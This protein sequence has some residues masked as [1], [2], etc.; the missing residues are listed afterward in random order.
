MQTRLHLETGTDRAE[1]VYY[2]TSH[3]FTSMTASLN[4]HR[5]LRIYSGGRVSRSGAQMLY[6]LFLK[7][8]FG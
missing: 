3:L 7:W 6:T 1:T 8:F 4:E 2:A 5:P